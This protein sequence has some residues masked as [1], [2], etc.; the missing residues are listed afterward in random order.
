M[1]K[2]NKL[3]A[4][5]TLSLISLSVQAEN[6]KFNEKEEFKND[7][8]IIKD[9]DKKLTGLE[10]DFKLENYNLI[11]GV[12]FL[13]NKEG[14][15]Y[16]GISRLEKINFD[17]EEI[18]LN[19]L[20]ISK[21]KEIVPLFKSEYSYLT[22][23]NNKVFV[24]NKNKNR[25]EELDI[26]NPKKLFS[27]VNG[28]SFIFTDEGVYIYEKEEEY[29]SYKKAI[30]KKTN[31]P[32]QY[33]F[34]NYDE[35]TLELIKE[36]KLKIEELES[37]TRYDSFYYNTGSYFYW[38]NK[39]KNNKEDYTLWI[40]NWK[41]TSKEGFPYPAISR[42]SYSCGDSMKKEEQEKV[43]QI[44]VKLSEEKFKEERE[45]FTYTINHKDKPEKVSYE[46]RKVLYKLSQKQL[47]FYTNDNQIIKQE[48]FVNPIMKSPCASYNIKE[49]YEDKKYLYF[50]DYRIKEKNNE[51]IQEK[52]AI[53]VDKN[54]IEKRYMYV[55][56][57]K[58]ILEL[59]NGEFQIIK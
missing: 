21:V 48:V 59:K 50:V 19:K 17:F 11:N 20:K 5:I 37:I 51:E 15:I 49:A 3:N 9:K 26:T 2:Y 33:K 22:I 31:L 12:L 6:G 28:E 44:P 40:K 24:K 16:S 30:N 54:N 1:L 25:W 46:E 32:T 53:V 43:D 39:G 27:S 56:D 14:E 34:K 10:S 8:I 41:V 7:S 47:D 29:S 45:I 58:E 4:I 18:E 13:E 55:S 35:K 52:N 36:K 38:S 42:T 57:I 23:K